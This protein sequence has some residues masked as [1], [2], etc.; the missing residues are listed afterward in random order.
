VFEHARSARA[1][2]E[3]RAVVLARLQRLR[4]RCAAYKHVPPARIYGQKDAPP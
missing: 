1:R 2:G 3:P 4:L